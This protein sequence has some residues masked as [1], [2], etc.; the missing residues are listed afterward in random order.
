MYFI[1]ENF[2][3]GVFKV[4]S[5]LNPQGLFI[6]GI[7][8]PYQNIKNVLW[9]AMGFIPL[10][11]KLYAVPSALSKIGCTFDLVPFLCIR[12][13]LQSG[14][15]FQEPGIWG[16]WLPHCWGDNCHIAHSS[17]KEQTTTSSTEAWLYKLQY[18]T[19]MRCNNNH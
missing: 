6:N 5:E 18:I 1:Q 14:N 9:T 15:Y 17:K 7:L 8:I 16:D 11:Y 12:K 2:R 10:G 13:D 19:T 4:F 3:P